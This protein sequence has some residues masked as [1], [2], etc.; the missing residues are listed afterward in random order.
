MNIILEIW[1][2]KSNCDSG[3]SPPTYPSTYPTNCLTAP[4]DF[5]AFPLKELI[6][7]YSSLLPTSTN[8]FSNITARNYELANTIYKHKIV[9]YKTFNAIYLH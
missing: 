2:S 4:Q 7:F 5:D 3:G 6:S 8:Y 9:D 1:G